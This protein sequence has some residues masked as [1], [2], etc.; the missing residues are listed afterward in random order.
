MIP[1]TGTSESVIKY[2]SNFMIRLR[3][4]C[5]FLLI[6]PELEF[7]RGSYR[8]R[9]SLEPELLV[10]RHS[11]KRCVLT[12]YHSKDWYLDTHQFNTHPYT[13]IFD[14]DSWFTIITCTKFLTDFLEQVPLIGNCSGSKEERILHLRCKWSS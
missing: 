12:I 14:N 13:P 9:Q 7:H 8:T 5:F 4:V 1:C 3:F 11:N 10:S 6:P 2:K